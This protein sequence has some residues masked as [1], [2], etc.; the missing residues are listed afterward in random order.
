MPIVDL[1]WCVPPSETD[2]PTSKIEERTIQPRQGA[3][4]V[5]RVYHFRHSGMVGSYIDFPGHIVT[6]DDGIDAANCPPERLFRVP[7]TVLR[8]DRKSDSGA[9][10]A[11]DLTECAPNGVPADSGALVLNALG[12]RRFDQIAIRSVFLDPSAVDWIIATGIHLLVSDIYESTPGYG[13]FGRLFAAGIST[14]CCPINL[15]CLPAGQ[16]IRV[17]ALPIRFPGVTQLP[18]RVLAEIP[19]HEGMP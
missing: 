6:T 16:M 2:S 13:M 7:G 3:P 18:C 12:A 11:A 5:A 8:L 1:T 9:V 14:V 17:T 4:Y 15:H 10:T 19:D